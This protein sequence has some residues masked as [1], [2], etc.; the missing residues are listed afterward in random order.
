MTSACDTPAALPRE[1]QYALV[2][3][4]ICAVASNC[5]GARE[6]DGVGFNGQDTKFGKRIAGVPFEMWTEDVRIAAARIALT[7]KAQIL[8]YT[9]IDMTALE[10]V[11][12]AQGRDSHRARDEA[13]GFERMHRRQVRVRDIDVVV[14]DF[15][16]DPALKDKLKAAGPVRWFPEDKTWEIARQALTAELVKVA[17]ANFVDI[18]PEAQAAFDN[19]GGGGQ[20]P[21]T[22]ATA[23]RAPEPKEIHGFVKDGLLV[24]SFPYNPGQKDAVKAAGAR[25]DPAGKTWWIA[26][27]DAK[28]VAVLNAA[29]SVGLNLAPDARQAVEA[30]G[31]R[32]EAKL[33]RKA[34][35]VGASRVSRPE[36]VSPEFLALVQ[37]A[38][39]R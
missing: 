24:L 1:E 16:Y 18:T 25:F 28:A 8:S 36:E 35:L 9:G 33:D 22:P 21:T 34:V 38:V 27:N 7:Y 12:A 13:R 3:A 5:D 19:C 39:A 4:G 30:A 29:V 11:Q 32:Q 26:I 20:P 23:T 37:A 14:F 10:V 31:A 6:Q 2:Y 15:P 17:V